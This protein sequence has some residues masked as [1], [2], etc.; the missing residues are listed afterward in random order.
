MT[1]ESKIELS[2]DRP[3]SPFLNLLIK[4]SA[5]VIAF[6]VTV[7]IMFLLAKSRLLA[8]IFIVVAGCAT[9][10]IFTLWIIWRSGRSNT[11]KW[12]LTLLCISLVLAALGFR[13]YNRYHTAAVMNIPVREFSNA[14]YPEDPALRSAHHGKYNGRELVLTQRDASHFDFVFEPMSP[15]V[16]KVTFRNIDVGLMTPN[17]P[18]WS[19]DDPG[20]LRIAITD[21]QWNRQ[22]VQ[23][24]AG[25]LHIEVEGGDGFEKTNLV[26]AELAKNCL[27]A[28]LWELQLFTNENGNKSLYY[29]GWFTFPLG[30]YKQ[31]FERSTG[32]SYRNH[33]Y[34]LEHWVDPAGTPIALSK[35]RKVVAEREI[36][37]A[38]DPA[39]KILS[40]GEQLRK[41]R[42]LL[43]ENAVAWNDF[44][45][46]S[47][48]VQ[49]AAFIP[50]GRYSVDRPWGNEYSG[51]D[52]L[53][54]TV[55]RD[56]RSPGAENPLHEV[57]MVF[58]SSAGPGIS[59][60]F[61]SGFD[62]RS[63]PQLPAADYPKGMYM[64]MGI[65]IPP[66]FQAYEPLTKSPPHL[67]PYF[68]VLLDANDRWIDHHRS[69]ID[70][71]VMH[72]DEVKE[73]VVHAYFLSYE[74]H[75]LINHIA[76]SIN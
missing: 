42:T 39:E 70:G 40:S 12:M 18:A 22:Q 37:A 41:R 64:P 25:S 51:I 21:R 3:T 6:V 66:F 63:L 28:G 45:K 74:R 71:I 68:S 23:F 72:R 59:R 5:V 8:P 16:A 17:L 14:E 36:V 32:L 9:A 53:K 49:F 76:F 75:T 52:Q 31:I 2:P 50:P 61:V 65:G 1:S 62:L 7:L 46:S 27:N 30:H 57:E 54:K 43:A 67:S 60:F 47:N 56:I 48:S 35:L 29:Q 58:E 15:H 11:L 4:P 34:Y 26:S 33:F 38:F 73:D 13:T 24:P 69:A 20:L 44:Y 55:L 10:V 19:L